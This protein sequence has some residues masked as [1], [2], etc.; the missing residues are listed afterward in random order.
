MDSI[1]FVQE[2]SHSIQSDTN[3][4]PKI[5]IKVDMK[6]TN[7]ALEWNVIVAISTKTDDKD[8]LTH[9]FMAQPYTTLE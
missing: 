4:P 7:Y 8:P 2:V 9:V 6:K 1:I 5:L 3:T